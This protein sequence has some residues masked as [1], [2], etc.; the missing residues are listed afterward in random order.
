MPLL[1][2]VSHESPKIKDVPNLSGAVFALTILFSL[3]YW[4]NHVLPP[5]ERASRAVRQ[6]PTQ[7]AANRKAG[8][9][10][11]SLDSAA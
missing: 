3:G 7:R 4:L 10:Q 1:S 6:L 9:D 5:V 11:G 2:H 8:S